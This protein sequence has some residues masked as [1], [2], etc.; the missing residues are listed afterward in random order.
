VWF[1]AE[2]TDIPVRVDDLPLRGGM[3]PTG[4]GI[5][6]LLNQFTHSRAASGYSTSFKTIG[7]DQ[8]LPGSETP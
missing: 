8:I 1:Y 2:M 7:E 5:R 4:S 3:L 6:R